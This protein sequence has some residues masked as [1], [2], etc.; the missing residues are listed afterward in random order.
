MPGR[1]DRVQNDRVRNERG[2]SVMPPIV[3]P[4]ALCFNAAVPFLLIFAQHSGRSGM[5][6]TF[7]RDSMSHGR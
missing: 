2:R 7:Q 4:F 5:Q 1:N 6:N 3:R